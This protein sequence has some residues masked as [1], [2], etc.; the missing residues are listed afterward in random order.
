MYKKINFLKNKAD[1]FLVIF[2]II[3]ISNEL[4]YFRFQI[5]E[6]IIFAP[7]ILMLLFL[8]YVFI[9]LP[10]RKLK[11]III[12]KENLIYFLIFFTYIF[13]SLVLFNEYF[14]SEYFIKFSKI[15]IYDLIKYFF[16]YIF[17]CIIGLNLIENANLKLLFK[18]ILILSCA[19]ILIGLFF[20]LY[21]FITEEELISRL[22]YYNDFSIVGLRFYSLFGEPRNASVTLISLVCLSIIIFKNLK[23]YQKKQFWPWVFIL[24]LLSMFSFFMT[25]SFTG[26][27]TLII[28]IFLSIIMILIHEIKKKNFNRL[29]LFILIFFIF[30]ILVS[31]TFYNVGRFYEY[32][33]EFIRI[34]KILFNTGIENTVLDL[35]TR[36]RTQ[37]R[38][39]AQLKDVMPVLTYISY[40]LELDISKIIFGNGSY[41]SYFVETKDFV[42]PHSFISRILYDNGFIGILLLTIFVFSSLKKESDIIDKLCLSFAF[43]GFLALNST[44]LFILLMFNLYFK[45]I[46]YEFKNKF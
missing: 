5:F 8:I 20:L 21:Y 24:F 9:S 46:N 43:A 38:L 26:L 29:F 19:I 2:G 42:A 35:K 34:F 33:L 28:G 18:V 12:V 32:L 16:L 22:F 31:I 37:T 7:R 23:I 3:I 27:L 15:L 10:D 13:F 40:I 17:F 30:L 1:I 4:N 41:A 45:K 39:Y 25:K 6:N 44:F 36:L 11:N 14:F